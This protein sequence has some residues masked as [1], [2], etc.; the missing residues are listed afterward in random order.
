VEVERGAQEWR[1]RDWTRVED[2]D[3]SGPDDPHYV[4]KV[5][6]G[7]IRFGDAVNGQIPQVPTD[8]QRKNIRV[9]S[10][11]TG[12]GEK[13]NVVASAINRFAEPYGITLGRLAELEVLNPMPA[14]GGSEAE[15]LEEA[16]ARARLDLKVPYQA[17]TSADYEQLALMT[18]GL[19]VA[20][21]RAIPLFSPELQNYPRERARAS[22][23]VVVVPYSL[24]SKP[25][26]S[27]AFLRSVCRHLDQH[28]LLTTRVY[29]VAPDYVRV[30]VQATVRLRPGFDSTSMMQ[31]ITRALDN[32]LRPLPAEDVAQSEGWAFGRTVYKS[33][34]YQII[35]GVEGVDC[36]EKVAL[37]AEGPGVARSPEGNILITPQSLVH[38][39]EH[40]IET[41]SPHT[42]CIVANDH[43]QAEDTDKGKLDRER[44]RRE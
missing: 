3:A 35:E 26:P 18:P 42:Q 32:F 40:Q 16:E 37:V 6:T 21:A 19:R 14:A 44:G 8:E 2:F 36:A 34:I 4:L 25:V 20:R 38:P 39:G 11:R 13:G 10:A 9:I 22:V 29:V 12:G 30:S 28:R 41:L 17:V 27:S 7:E 23:T 15:S 24:S 43:T 5:S 31:A 1:W 33:E